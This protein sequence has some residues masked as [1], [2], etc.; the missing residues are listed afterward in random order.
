MPFGDY[1]TLGA[2]LRDFQIAEM[3]QDFLE[4]APITASD[5]LRAW[6]DETFRDYNPTCSEWAVCESLIYPVLRETH[7][8]YAQDLVIWMH[9]PLYQGP[10]LLGV[11]DYMISKRSPLSVQVMEPPLA[12][13]IEAKRNDFDAGWGQCVAAMVAGQRLN[14]PTTRPIYGT[15]SDGFVWRFGKLEG[16]TFT[17]QT[18]EFTL[19]RL[20]ELC[21]ALHQMFDLCRRQVM[22]PVE[23]A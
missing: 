7:R 14:G 1:S 6:L 20:D 2:A 19:S 8:P 21:A 16:S 12:M 5:D 17:H 18:L 22:I 11:P 15:V 23:A 13:I 3:R 9:V 10:T 4:L